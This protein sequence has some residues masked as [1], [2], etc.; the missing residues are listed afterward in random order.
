MTFSFG[1][2]LKELILMNEL[3]SSGGVGFINVDNKRDVLIY[4]GRPFSI[5]SGEGFLNNFSINTIM[6]YKLKAG[7]E[8][9]GDI[10]KRR[11]GMKLAR[12]FVDGG[13]KIPQAVFVSLF[14]KKFLD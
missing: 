4:N 13:I 11:V 3:L 9:E 14:E 2:D 12:M 8:W 6:K 10:D 5:K 1:M 7:G